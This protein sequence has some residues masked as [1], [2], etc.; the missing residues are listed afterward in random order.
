M[1]IME[2]LDIVIG[3][4]RLR[5]DVFHTAWSDP[6]LH[7]YL[8]PNGYIHY[9]PPIPIQNTIPSVVEVTRSINTTFAISRHLI[10]M[11]RK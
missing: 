10:A 6:I 9:T 5:S 11:S 7:I 1:K 4:S 3:K 2:I 8:I